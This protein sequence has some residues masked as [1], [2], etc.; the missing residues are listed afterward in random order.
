MFSEI[1]ISNQCIKLGIQ[2]ESK[3]EIGERSQMCY[4]GFVFLFSNVSCVS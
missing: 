4:F 2:G 1:G 3:E